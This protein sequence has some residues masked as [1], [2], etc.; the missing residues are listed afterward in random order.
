VLT[1]TVFLFIPINLAQASAKCSQKE[2]SVFRESLKPSNQLKIIKQELEECG[3]ILVPGEIMK[4]LMMSF[5]ATMEDLTMMEKGY[6]HENLPRDQQPVMK[7]RQTAGHRMLLNPSSNEIGQSY[8]HVCTKFPRQEIASTTS[9]GSK[10][11]YKR[12]GAR[13]ARIVPDSYSSSTIPYAMAAINMHLSPEKH[14]N[15]ENLNISH[16]VTINDQ[17][18]QGE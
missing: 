18:G 1:V 13:C 10:L 3:F 5:G 16:P 11:N 9:E 6:V 7:H 4:S 2:K 15:Q 14:H 17:L 12:Y 8:T